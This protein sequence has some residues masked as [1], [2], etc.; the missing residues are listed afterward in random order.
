MTDSLAAKA[1][2]LLSSGRDEEA[3]AT[4]L[5][6]LSNAPASP[7]AWFNLAY[8]QRRTGR[9][10]DALRS[11]QAALDHGARSPEEVHVNRAAIFSEYLNR[12]DLAVRELEAA[13]IVRP[14]YVHALFNLATIYEDLG[15]PAAARLRY[16]EVLA[17]VADHAVALARV[18]MLDIHA[19]NAAGAVGDTTHALGRRQWHAEDA[20]E[21]QFA[22]A[23]ALDATGQHAAA[24]EALTFANTVSREAARSNGFVY[25]R[26]RQEALVDAL[27]DT[28]PLKHQASS[29]GGNVPIF[30][31][32]LFRSGSTLVEQ[33]LAAHRDVTNGGE[34]EV[35]PTLIR[36]RIE[37][38]PPALRA[39]SI[40]DL[41]DLRS[42]YLAET[43]KLV[44]E[45]R[46]ITD[47]RPDNFLHIGLI[48][49]LFPE[50]KIVH[51]YRDVADNLLSIYFLNFQHAVSYGFDLDDIAHWIGQYRRLMEHWKSV[52]GSD[53]IALD[54]DELVQWPETVVGR[55]L[56]ACGL[57]WDANCLAP[58]LVENVVRTA[59]VLQ[60]REALH[61]RAS[62]R[63]RGYAPFL[64]D[65][66]R[67][68]DV[69]KF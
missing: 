68:L 17:A 1:A 42:R 25:D 69:S 21:L 48:K 29:E 31:C 67:Q 13:L 46:Q 3:I 53:I 44:P 41:N 60:V 23:R 6:L 56:Q 47:K 20:A 5:H 62:G 49:S 19:G 33:I 11:Y 26:Q 27:I 38:Y 59:S 54:Y 39:A 30:I 66:L 43:S 35:L 34:L 24:F 12:S 45:F 28:F 37:S 50:A 40:S 58:Q 7:D 36:D 4:Y 52:Y 22:R 14:G 51:S 18:A 15:D 64:A 57:P 10:D 9:Y 65:A 16:R 32:G 2:Q 63:A 61:R 55:L 8:L